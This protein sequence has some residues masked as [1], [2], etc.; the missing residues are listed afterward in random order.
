MSDTEN[1]ANENVPAR[2]EDRFQ[3]EQFLPLRNMIRHISQLAELDPVDSQLIAAR[4][5]NM[6]AMA[7]TPEQ[8]I[9]AAESGA[10]DAADYLGRPLGLMAVQFDKSDDSY[11]EGTLG[12]YAI[13]QIQLAERPETKEDPLIITIGAPNVVAAVY[14]WM[15]QGVVSDD[16]P[17]WFIIN[18][19]KTKRGTLYTV[20]GV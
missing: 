16:N 14:Q 12:Y 11:E 3:T 7:E 2:M 6:I 15:R 9:E 17:Y 4:V 8:V 19:R 10:A 13:L 5:I 1:T 20:R 18:G